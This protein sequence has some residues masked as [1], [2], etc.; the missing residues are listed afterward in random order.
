MTEALP[1]TSRQRTVV[2]LR[3]Q[4]RGRRQIAHA[5]GVSARTVKADLDAARSTIGARDETEL[6]LCID[7]LQRGVPA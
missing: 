3:L 4:G 2:E 1:L 7:R 6:L 5:L